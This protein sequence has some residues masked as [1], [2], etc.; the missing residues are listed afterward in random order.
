MA[1]VTPP[2]MIVLVALVA[3]F[4]PAFDPGALAQGVAFQPEVSPLFNGA[5]LGVTPVVSADRRYVRMSLDVA[6]S[7]I[8]G[9]TT[10]SVPAAVSGAG[11]GMGGLGGLNGLLGTGGGGGGTGRLGSLNQGDGPLAGPFAF[12]G[13][14]GQPI[15]RDV[16]NPDAVNWP[17]ISPDGEGAAQE[18]TPIEPVATSGVAQ[19]RKVQANIKAV[20]SQRAAALR[21]SRRQ[22]LAASRRGR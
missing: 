13:D 7:N 9:F 10:Y 20:Q 6:F 19:R 2:R 1:G 15:F 16:Q 21:S 4:S 17:K 14:G 18:H 3:G 11:G 12:G 22:N 5:L 8:N